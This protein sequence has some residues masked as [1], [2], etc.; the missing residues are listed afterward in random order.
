MRSNGDKGGTFRSQPILAVGDSFTFGDEVHDDETWPAILEQL[1]RQRVINGGVFGYGTDQAFL[2]LRNLL[3]IYEPRSVVFSFIP[4]DLSRCEH[5]MTLGVRKPYFSARNGSLQLVKP[6]IRQPSPNP[7]VKSTIGHSFLVHKIMMRLSPNWWLSGGMR[8]NED[9]TGE[10]GANITCMI[11]RE[12]NELAKVLEG[13]IYILVQ[14]TRRQYPPEVHAQVDR[15]LS[16]VDHNLITVLD[17]RDDLERIRGADP[18]RHASYFRVHMTYK[19]NYFVAEK[20][21]EVIRNTGGDAP[22]E[23]P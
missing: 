12:M 17:L 23:L 19:G 15:A 16:C 4:G 9:H 21:A 11:F 22:G 8:F 20:L 1:L 14:S 10:S 5:A 6:P 18:E 13:R 3:P 7:G 2:R